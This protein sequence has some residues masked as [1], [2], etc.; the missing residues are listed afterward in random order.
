MTARLTQNLQV[1]FLLWTQTQNSSA[2]IALDFFQPCWSQTQSLELAGG[3][4]GAHGQVPAWRSK[5][6]HA[7][8]WVW[9]GTGTPKLFFS[10]LRGKWGLSASRHPLGPELEPWAL[11]GRFHLSMAAKGHEA[12][13]LQQAFK[14]YSFYQATSFSTNRWYF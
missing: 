14:P 10:P 8:V 2:G 12:G 3:D 1:Q 9:A 11:P 13:T 7:D 4:R 5:H 6:G